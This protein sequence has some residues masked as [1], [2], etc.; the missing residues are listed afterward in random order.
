MVRVNGPITLGFP[1]YKG[2]L[3]NRVVNIYLLVNIL[4]DFVRVFNNFI[5]FCFIHILFGFVFIHA[6]LSRYV[7]ISAKFLS[8]LVSETSFYNLNLVTFLR[9]ELQILSMS[10]FLKSY[11]SK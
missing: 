6:R 8:F 11:P 1:G 3:Y 9:R 5:W 4:V 7:C 10:N 2:H